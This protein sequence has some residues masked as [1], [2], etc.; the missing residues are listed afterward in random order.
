MLA[1]AS[2][3]GDRR[4]DAMKLARAYET[5]AGALA[6][7]AAGRAAPLPALMSAL[8]VDHSTLARAHA[9]NRR[10]AAIRA[11]AAV[12]RGERRLGAVLDQVSGA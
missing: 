12:D 1:D 8:A 5:A 10:E 6:P 2:S 7:V 11:G 9:R 3:R 4:R